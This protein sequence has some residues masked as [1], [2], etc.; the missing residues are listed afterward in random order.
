[1]RSRIFRSV[2]PLFLLCFAVF[3]LALLGAPGPS[4]ADAP[5]GP[6][7]RIQK[8]VVA[9]TWYPGSPSEL[10][11]TVEGYFAKVPAESYPGR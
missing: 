1:M 11:K 6:Q 7:L 8:S 10:R 4:C 2:L 9:G 3:A 5:K